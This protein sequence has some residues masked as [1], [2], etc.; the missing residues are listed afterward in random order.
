MF[1]RL[2]L[3]V[4]AMRHARRYKLICA[5]S[6]ELHVNHGFPWRHVT[7]RMQFPS[8]TVLC[9]I[10]FSPVSSKCDGFRYVPYLYAV[11]AV[12]SGCTEDRRRS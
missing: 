3:T 5:K 9:L 11:F 4:I 7:S 8:V 10:P 1:G 2:H 12:S 6:V